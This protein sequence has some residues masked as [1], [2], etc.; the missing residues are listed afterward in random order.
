[1]KKIRIGTSTDDSTSSDSSDEEMETS[2]A[3]TI[4][5]TSES[6]T[7]EGPST[8]N[9]MMAAD[10]KKPSLR[11]FTLTRVTVGDKETILDMPE[12]RNNFSDHVIGVSWFI[13][14]S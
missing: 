7:I 5:V 10:F 11:A 13:W 8:T 3:E 4:A 2:E 1:M 9:Q 14:F 12:R 6:K